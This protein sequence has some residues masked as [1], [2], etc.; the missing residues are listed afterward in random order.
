MDRK[1]I[2]A[3]NWKLNGDRFLVQDF[4]EGFANTSLTKVSPILCLPSVYLATVQGAKFAVGA[5][6]VSDR[7]SGAFTG[8]ISVDMLKDV[9]AEFVIIGHSER[10]E[11]FQETNQVIAKKLSTAIAAG[12]TPIFCIG[13]SLETRESGS[14][15]EFLSEQLASAI[16]EIGIAG[17]DKCII[18]YEPIWAIG[19]G[20]T[21]TPAQAQEVHAF[22]RN[23]LAEH[24]TGIAANT[25]I[26]YGGSVNATSA[27]ALFA[28]QDIDG[29]LVGG[30]SLKLKEFLEI[31]QAAEQ[32]G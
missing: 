15:F 26:L 31:C 13:E 24:D 9:N 19:T 30:A 22:I 5:Q 28:E 29:G 21:A 17:V 6:N 14:M 3:G 1:M 20:L 10:R 18:A 7:A 8:E 25:A 32:R 12:L 23:F 2:V 11:M 16:A 4:L 27:P